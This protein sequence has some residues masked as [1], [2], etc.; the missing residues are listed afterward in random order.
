MK[1]AH[2][3]DVTAIDWSRFKYMVFDLPKQ[4]GTYEERYAAL[5]TFSFFTPFFVANYKNNNYNTS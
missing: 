2:R 5:G 3:M 1:I 4:E